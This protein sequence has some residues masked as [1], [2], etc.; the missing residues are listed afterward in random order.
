MTFYISISYW[1]QIFS[2][3]VFIILSY[4]NKLFHQKRSRLK[5][6]NWVTKW[7]NS[8]GGLPTI[9]NHTYFFLTCKLLSFFFFKNPDLVSGQVKVFKKDGGNCFWQ[10]FEPG[11]ISFGLATNQGPGPLSVMG[12]GGSTLKPKKVH[13]YP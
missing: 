5:L 4:I 12:G 1:W 10:L 11:C 7:I 8:L 2:Q 6:L 3:E 9:L 13:C